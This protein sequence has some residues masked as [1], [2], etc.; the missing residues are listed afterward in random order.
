MSVT[1]EALTELWRALRAEREERLRATEALAAE[2]R[3]ELKL[4]ADAIT[5]RIDSVH[6]EALRVLTER[7]ERSSRT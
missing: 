4:A 6:T 3:A 5:E 2:L 7:A 1:D